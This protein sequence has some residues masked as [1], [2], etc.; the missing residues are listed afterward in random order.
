MHPYLETKT[1]GKTENHMISTWMCTPQLHLSREPQGPMHAAPREKVDER[2]ENEDNEEGT[3]TYGTQ[4]ERCGPI[5]KSS[6]S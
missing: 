2:E 6:R 5:R 3:R 1:A 4:L